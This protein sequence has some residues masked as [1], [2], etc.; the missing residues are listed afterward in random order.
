MKKY[1]LSFHTVFI[2]N[3]NIKWLEEFLI[4]Y[5]NIIGIEQFYLYDNDK[6]DGGDGDKEYNKY[7]FKINTDNSE[8]DI[9]LF[10]NLKTKYKKYITHI[11]WQPKNDKGDIIYGQEESIKHFINNYSKDNTWTLFLDLDEFIYSHNNIILKEY[12]LKLDDNISCIKI[13][14]KKFIDRFL[15][16]KFYI[17]QDFNCINQIFNWSP[18]NIVKCDD[19]INTNTIHDF[20]VKN[21]SYNENPNILRFNHYNVNNKQLLWMANFYNSSIPFT[22]NS[23]DNGMEKYNYLFY[24]KNY[25]Y[26][27]III[28]IIIIIF[29]FLVKK[30]HYI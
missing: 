3:E 25:N 2:L 20:I 12:L 16:D 30:N 8:N 5:I 23:Y 1:Y 15:S 10:N 29:I 7:G 27:Y 14:Q 22:L 21:K 17:T 26:N 4:Y 24:D 18:K 13:C 19:F 6:S 9:L 11:K 28:I